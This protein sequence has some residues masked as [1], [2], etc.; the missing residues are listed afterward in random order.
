M[1]LMWIRL[2]EVHFLVDK[3]LFVPCG[4]IKLYGALRVSGQMQ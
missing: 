2:N 1:P 4:V 3:I